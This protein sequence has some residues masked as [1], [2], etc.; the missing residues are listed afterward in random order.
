MSEPQEDEPLPPGGQEDE[1]AD[2]LRRCFCGSYGSASD[3]SNQFVEFWDLSDIAELIKKQSYM[4]GKPAAM[5]IIRLITKQVKKLGVHDRYHKVEC[6][7][8]IADDDKHSCSLITDHIPVSD[9][10]L[11]VYKRQTQTT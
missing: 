3:R 2:R 8:C 1:P 11:D 9:T 5:L 10:H 4:I 6:V 7:I